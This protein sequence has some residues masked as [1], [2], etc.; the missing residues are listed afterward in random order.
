MILL[1]AIIAKISH[2]EFSG[3][4]INVVLCHLFPEMHPSVIMLMGK[5]SVCYHAD[6][7]I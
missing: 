7:E 5:S 2:F 4:L 3:F 6:G 1:V